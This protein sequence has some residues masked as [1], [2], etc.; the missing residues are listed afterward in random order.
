V[1]VAKRD[2][3]LD[4]EI[5]YR[6]S[7]NSRETG[8]P[9][10]TKQSP[11]Y[12][13]QRLI[14]YRQLARGGRLEF[15]WHTVERELQVLEN[16]GLHAEAVGAVING[17]MSDRTR[18]EQQFAEVNAKL[19]RLIVLSRTAAI[20]FT[21]KAGHRDPAYHSVR[22]TSWIRSSHSALVVR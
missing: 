14:S 11:Y 21:H 22:V 3:M 19:D 7:T 17:A 9:S 13:R 15:N 10:H 18:V 2:W 4:L 1:S 12:V 16:P 8:S 5:G 20:L 6:P